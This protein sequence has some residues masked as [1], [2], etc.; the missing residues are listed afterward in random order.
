MTLHLTLRRAEGALV[1][2]L[3][4]V[5]RRGYEIVHLVVRPEGEA[6]SVSLTV[7]GGR[8]ADVLARHIG[9]LFDVTR[10]EVA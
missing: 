1:R 7:E 3:G 4:L 8:P 2:V 10:V 6:L 9:K 5:G